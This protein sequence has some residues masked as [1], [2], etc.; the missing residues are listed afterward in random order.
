MR[1]TVHTR[2]V[3]STGKYVVPYFLT[4][5]LKLHPGVE[6]RLDVTNK[7][8]VID[9]IL[10]NEVDFSMVSLLPDIENIDNLELLQ[11]K[12]YFVTGS[13][14]L[15]TNKEYNISILKDLPI[16]FREQGSGT[17]TTMEKFFESHGIQLKN[18]I[19]LTSNEAVKQAIIAGI[20]NSVMPLIGIKSEL[21]NG[22][23]K[24][25]PIKGFPITTNWQLIW[26]KNKKFSPVAKAFLEYLQQ[27][28][29]T[30]IQKYFSWFE[31]Y[32]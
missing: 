31:E 32:A 2:Y 22:T 30:I 15:I 18:K 11:N 21:M 6:L 25:I 17:R 28:K 5:F 23:L 9:D 1:T 7:S 27:E 3:V 10:K 24:V 29:F 4:D 8:K 14:D 16:L 13:N 19:E 26:S 12:L 20:G